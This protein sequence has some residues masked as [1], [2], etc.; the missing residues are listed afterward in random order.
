MRALAS[1]FLLLCALLA[2]ALQSDLSAAKQAEREGRT[3]E[4]I[5]LYREYLQ[6]HPDD[7]VAEYSL[8]ALLLRKG[9]YEEAAKHLERASRLQPN[10]AEPNLALASA[11]L[12]L[13]RPADALAALRRAEVAAGSAAEY[14]SM[15]S[16]I[17]ALL[18]DPAACDS[19]T[20]AHSLAPTRLDIAL[21]AAAVLSSFGKHKEAA[22][23]YQKAYEISPTN[24]ELRISRGQELL[25]GGEADAALRL[26]EEILSGQPNQTGA[27]LLKARA[28]LTLKRPEQALGFLEQAL[29]GGTDAIR[30][31]P[32]RAEC[33]VQL[34]RETE[35]AE[36]LDE[37]AHSAPGDPEIQ[38]ARARL[39]LKMG[40]FS[41]AERSA[42]QLLRVAPIWPESYLVALEV[43]RSQQKKTA[44]EII[45]RNWIAFLP[46]DPRPY[47]P[48]AERL[49]SRD[50]WAE[51]AV[52][53][54]NYLRIRPKD[55]DAFALMA[56]AFLGSGDATTPIARL[57]AALDQGIESEAM[58]LYLALAYRKQ[59][60]NG[61]AIRTLETLVRRYPKSERGWS[62]LAT[63]QEPTRP[64]GALQAYTRMLEALPGNLEAIKGRARMLG[65]VGRHE[66][67][68]EEWIRLAQEQ[69]SPG[70]YYYAAMEYREAK[71]PEKADAMWKR[72]TA[73]RSED[74]ELLSVYAQFLADVERVDEA[75]DVLLRMTRIAPQNPDVYLTGARILVDRERPKEA[76]EL[77][78]LGSTV[79]YKNFQ[80]FQLLSKASV[81]AK[82]AESSTTITEALFQ[83]ELFSVPMMVAYVDGQARIGKLAEAIRSI[84]AATEK[85]PKETALFV[86]LARAK[87]LAGD[88]R[89]ALQAL[90]RAVELSPGDV[91]TLQVYAQAAE[92]EGDATRA[93]R[94]FE[95]LAKA[96][97]SEPNY[98][99]KQA[100]YLRDLGKK[101][102]AIAAL[103][104]AL[105][106]FPGNP[107]ILKML[108]SLGG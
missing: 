7:F 35:A 11:Y 91:E 30:V 93:A 107:E 72:L 32:I 105:E 44:E 14:W 53:L 101:E 49:L 54:D 57:N 82:D 69:K 3:D 63:I 68:A 6:S 38:A 71:A 31:A 43:A 26:A 51:A 59:Q 62:L 79:L 16:G 33:L 66:E 58:Y 46:N 21:Q 1:A 83:K 99:L 18:G 84:T 94:A 88:G 106:R 98:V 22:S 75:R 23:M 95:L 74:V 37:A 28:L 52:V 17:E 108:E 12:S 61:E 81:A 85:H 80:F 27:V 64:E 36:V 13:Q 4:A 104:N 5:R 47:K 8:G 50:S 9:D 97:P 40:K 10:R 48:L 15:R 70:P 89:G 2:V 78:R 19:A 42:D 76:I 100:G 55:A 60:E 103:R 92:A 73:E 29:R 56:Q 77:L 25:S 45:L 41:E 65:R 20:R 96:L 39:Y 102:E 24:Q 90:D 87:A 67:A 34:S 86:G